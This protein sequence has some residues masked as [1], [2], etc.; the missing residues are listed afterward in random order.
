MRSAAVAAAPAEEA[1]SPS[2]DDDAVEDIVPSR[3]G[4]SVGQAP[5]GRSM[6]ATLAT[7][8]AAVRAATE[9]WREFFLLLVEEKTISEKKRVVDRSFFFLLLSSFVVRSSSLES[10]QKC[11]FAFPRAFTH[12]QTTLMPGVHKKTEKKCTKTTSKPNINTLK[13]RKKSKQ[14]SLLLLLL[15][16][17]KNK[18]NKTYPYLRPERRKERA[19]DL[20][21]DVFGQRHPLRREMSLWF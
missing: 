11:S 7:T 20:R 17:E 18:T 12:R 21:L 9:T 6:A 5:A 15:S 1:V 10:A 14:Q 4:R 8:S 19:P 2:E 3:V 13:K 16:T